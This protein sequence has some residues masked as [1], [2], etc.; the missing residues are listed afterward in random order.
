[1]KITLDLPADVFDAGFPEDAFA[2]RMRQWAILALVDARRL[3]EH[4]AARM[5]GVERWELVE[6]MEALGMRP[7]EKVFDEIRGQLGR[8]IA[9][10]EGARQQGRT[11]MRFLHT[12]I[13]VN[14]LDQSAEVLLR[15]ARDEAAAAA[16]TIPTANSPWPSSATATRT[17]TR[18]SS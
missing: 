10:R 18:S 3:H 4:E 13:R 14:D 16:R 8:A 7:T 12:M 17:T 6:R 9:A 15:P 2:A 11:T 5:L 1:M